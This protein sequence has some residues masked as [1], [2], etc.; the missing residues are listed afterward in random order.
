VDAEDRKAVGQLL[1]G[2]WTVLS[3]PLAVIGGAFLL[4]IAVRAFL[5]GATLH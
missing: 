1:A 4:G 3:I 2:I 5:W